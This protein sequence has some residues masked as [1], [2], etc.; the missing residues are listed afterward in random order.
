MSLKMTEP[1]KKRTAKSTW[2]ESEK[3]KS[4]RKVEVERVRESPQLDSSAKKGNG[5]I[6]LSRLRH[7]TNTGPK[8]WLVRHVWRWEWEGNRPGI[9]TWSDREQGLLEFEQ[10]VKFVLQG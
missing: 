1:K 8:D 5:F 9:R 10:Q 4:K 3:N 6:G 2:S 7:T